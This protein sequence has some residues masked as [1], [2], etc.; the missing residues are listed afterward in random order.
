M[1]DEPGVVWPD[2]LLLTCT[3]ERAPD[4]KIHR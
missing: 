2:T 1:E 4:Q 3:V